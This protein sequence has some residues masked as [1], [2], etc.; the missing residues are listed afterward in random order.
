MGRRCLR[1]RPSV[2]PFRRRVV[3]LGCLLSLQTVAVIG[4]AWRMSPT[5]DEVAHL[6]AAVRCATERDFDL[7]RVNPPLVRYVAGFAVTAAGCRTDWTSFNP[8]PGQRT[9]WQV[10]EDFIHAN[11]DRYLRLLFIGRM[12]VLP[13]AWIVTIVI[14]GWT[15]QIAGPSAACLAAAWWVVEPNA[16]GNSALL[17]C[18]VAATAT[19]TLAAWQFATWQQTPTLRNCVLTGL[20]AG[21]AALAKTVWIVLPVIWLTVIGLAMI[22]SRPGCRRVVLKVIQFGFLLFVI[23]LVINVGYRFDGTC[24][25]LGDFNFV[26]S[27]FRA[28]QSA[29]AGDDH[30]AGLA[31]EVPIPFPRSFIQ[32]IDEQRRDFE[33]GRGGYLMGEHR[34]SGCAHYYLA[35]AMV[36]EPLSLLI[37]VVLTIVILVVSCFAA[38][39]THRSSPIRHPLVVPMSHFLAILLLVS[40]QSGLNSYYRYLLPGIPFLIIAVGATLVPIARPLAGTLFML[41]FVESAVVFPQSLS[42]FNMAAGGPQHGGEYLLGS[43]LDWGQDLSELAV[44]MSQHPECAEVFLI[45]GGGCPPE[46]YGIPYAIPDFCQCG[47]SPVPA[48]ESDPAPEPGW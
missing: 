27:T 39:R 21:I 30:T 6:P 28:L 34:A 26:S 19:G 24:Q 5:N 41:T 22:R 36:K 8:A 3:T 37:A 32:G 13:F 17:T 10:G 31:A 45:S 9:E 7:Y 12:S 40:S 15:R 20:C 47:A 42:Y 43:N 44:W 46:L 23:T 33:R 38:G 14:W 29:V 11:R 35:A 18:D 4:L 2:P 48:V 25:R 1:K 16:L